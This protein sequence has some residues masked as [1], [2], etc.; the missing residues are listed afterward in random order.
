MKNCFANITPDSLTGAL[1]AIEGVLDAAVILNGPTG[2]KLY[3]SAISE[4]Q[5]PSQANYDPFSYPEEFYFGQPRIPCTYIDGYDYIYGCSDKLTKLLKDVKK[6]NYNLLAVVNSPGAALIGDDLNR[7]MKNELGDTPYFSMEST[8]FS[9]DFNQGFYNSMKKVI[10]LLWGE[11]KEVIPKTVNLIGISIYDKYFEG[12]IEELKRLL[13]LCG[14]DVISNICGGESTENIKKAIKAEYNVVIYPECG[15]QLAK[16][17]KKNYNIPYIVCEEGVS[18]GFDATESFIDDICK[19]LN[20]H[21]Q[22][23]KEELEKARAQSYVYLS[24]TTSFIGLPK[25]A[26][27]SIK[28]EASMAY[29]LCKWLCMYLAMIPASIEILPNKDNRYFTKLKNFLQNL[30]Y[31]NALNKDI[32]ECTGNIVFCDGN[33]ILSLRSCNKNFTGVEISLPSLGYIHVIPKTILGIKG[34][35]MFIEHIL[36]GVQFVNFK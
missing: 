21:E 9:G 19:K 7:L 2:C 27:F 5:M 24:R 32:H 4:G 29:A 33:T 23:F 15:L 18:I 30:G 3:H 35:L 34:A 25:G 36:N 16:W 17:M 31:H 12:N 28:A 11:R 14:I 13:K 6:R 8:G 22:L 20:G 1:F 26:T 10:T